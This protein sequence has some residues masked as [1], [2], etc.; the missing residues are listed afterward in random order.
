MMERTQR[1]AIDRQRYVS[2]PPPQNA[3]N[4]KNP[5]ELR[6]KREVTNKQMKQTV[7]GSMNQINETTKV[8]PPVR[9]K[10]PQKIQKKKT[11]KLSTPP[12]KPKVTKEAKKDNG[13]FKQMK[14]KFVGKPKDDSDK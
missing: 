1:P 7:S 4:K 9:S 5:N 10:P 8:K 13:I 3:V 2:K 14:D 11:K 12:R 6:T